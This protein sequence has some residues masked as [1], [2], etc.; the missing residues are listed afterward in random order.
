MLT[1]KRNKII[2]AFTGVFVLVIAVMIVV[3][4]LYDRSTRYDGSGFWEFFTL[5]AVC[6]Y[7]SAI[8]LK[9]FFEELAS[10]RIK[11]WLA[12]PGSRLR[13]M[14]RLLWKLFV[15]ISLVSAVYFGI[16]AATASIKSHTIPHNILVSFL[17]IL[18]IAAVLVALNV[19]LYYAVRSKYITLVSIVL[20]GIRVMSLI[21]STFINEVTD[22]ME[23]NTA[24]QEYFLPLG[25]GFKNLM[26]GCIPVNP[27][28]Q[29]DFIIFHK[30]TSVTE[31]L[32]PLV[33][34]LVVLSMVLY[35]FS[36]KEF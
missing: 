1:A 26:Y 17:G 14:L 16:I 34:S 3:L 4:E 27:I 7:A 15:H 24:Y 30:L 9:L 25:A 36:K 29:Q 12:L 2:I 5:F 32:Y 33:W 20:P 6:S 23:Y 13:Y 19:L 8:S 11:L 28:E 35:L 31:N 21:K 10:N 22:T 18:Q